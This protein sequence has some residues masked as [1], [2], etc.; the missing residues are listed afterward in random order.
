MILRRDNF[1]FVTS[2]AKSLINFEMVLAMEHH[3]LTIWFYIRIFQFVCLFKKK[4]VA[5]FFL[6]YS[7]RLNM[8]RACANNQ[9]AKLMSEPTYQNLI[10]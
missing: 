10:K 6:L 3:S 8:A 2:L 9:L 7:T 5:G 4:K 1:Y